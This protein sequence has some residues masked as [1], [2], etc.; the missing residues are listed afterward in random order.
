MPR[1]CRRSCRQRAYEARHPVGQAAVPPGANEPVTVTT[2]GPR[3]S[4][5]PS[6]VEV[7]QR[8]EDSVAAARAAR[9]KQL[10]PAVQAL[11][12]AVVD[13]CATE[14]LPLIGEQDEALWAL[15]APASRAVNDARSALGGRST[16]R[17]EHARQ[18]LL[19]AAVALANPVAY[20][21]RGIGRPSSLPIVVPGPDGVIPTGLVDCELERGARVVRWYPEGWTGQAELLPVVVGRPAEFRYRWNDRRV[22]DQL[23]EDLIV[24]CCGWRTAPKA[25][26]PALG[27]ARLGL[28][29]QLRVDIS[30]GTWTLQPTTIVGWLQRAGIVIAPAHKQ[31]VT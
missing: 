27:R 24:L 8:L 17:L 31:H 18:Q 23:A 4:A 25:L 19:A 30:K 5:G 2:S 9:S 12:A 22:W 21:A 7:R 20:A 1:Y 10:R 29:N 15:V 26:P 14:G 13:V 16:Q 28:G 6:A 11:A 3:S